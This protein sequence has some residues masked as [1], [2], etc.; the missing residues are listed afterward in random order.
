MGRKRGYQE[1]VFLLFP[2]YGW[3]REKNQNLI[4]SQHKS[5]FAPSQHRGEAGPGR[6]KGAERREERV[7]RGGDRG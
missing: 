6:F 4:P 2:S 3:E 7:G 1:G 5:M